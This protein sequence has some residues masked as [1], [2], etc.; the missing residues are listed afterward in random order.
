MLVLFSIIHRVLPLTF[1]IYSVYCILI[2]LRVQKQDKIVLTVK[3]FLNI[4]LFKRLIGEP[5]LPNG[6]D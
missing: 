5:N 2:P 1:Q 4:T 6:D 3:I